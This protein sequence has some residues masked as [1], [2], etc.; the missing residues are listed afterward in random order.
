VFKSR[1]IQDFGEFYGR[2]LFLAETS[3]TTGGL[4]SLLQPTGPLKKAQELASRAFGSQH[5]FF[6]TNGTS[7][8]NKIVV[9][10]WWSPATS[11]SSTATAT[12][13]TTTAWC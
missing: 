4:D 12:R 13:A 2:N 10:A 1:W 5:T 6:A 7:T 3:A 8:T 9:Q 11:C